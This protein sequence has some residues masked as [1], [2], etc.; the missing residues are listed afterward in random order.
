MSPSNKILVLLL[1]PILLVSSHPIPAEDP[2]KQCNLSEDDLTKLKAAISGASSAKAANEDILPNTTLAACPMLKNF[3]EMLKTVATDM[4]VLKTQGVSNME[5]QLL[6]ESFEEKLNDLAK[7]KDIFERQA[8]QDTSKAEGEM[9]EKI[10]KLQLEM[11]K[12]QEEIEEQTKQMYVD[13]I[14]YIFE[15]LKMN[16]TEAI[17]SYAQIVMKTKMHELIMKL[18]T[19]RLVLWE[20]V[21]YVEGKKNKWVGR[22]VLNTILDQVNK[23]KLY[24]PE[25]VEIGKNSLV[26]VWCWKFNSE[27]VYGT[28]DEDQKSFH[29]AKLFFPKEKGCKECANVKSRTMCNNDYPKVMVKAFG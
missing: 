10:N 12:L 22:K 17:D 23:L 20:M 3:T 15:R 4:E 9:V 29:L 7:N 25:E 8:N 27:T 1:F 19:D 5:V 11:A 16:D 28:T 2:A 26:V 13:M 14:E 6:R 24:K 18:K 21:K